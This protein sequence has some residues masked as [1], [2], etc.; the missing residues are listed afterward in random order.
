[1]GQDIDKAA[2]GRLLADCPIAEFTKGASLEEAFM[3]LTAGSL[4]YGDHY[5]KG[6]IA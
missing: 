6:G 1:V 3:A 5:Q 4:E 2:R